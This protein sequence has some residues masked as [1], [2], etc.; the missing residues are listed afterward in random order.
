MHRESGRMFKIVVRIRGNVYKSREN[1]EKSERMNKTVERMCKIIGKI[2]ENIVY[3][4][5]IRGNI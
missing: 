1:Q 5:R 4:G 3:N 2:R